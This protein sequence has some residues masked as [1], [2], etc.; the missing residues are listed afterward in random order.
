[1]K[2]AI[3]SDSHDNLANIYKFLDYINKEGICYVIH[4][5]DLCAPAV[6]REIIQKYDGEFHLVFG[7]VDGDHA[8]EEK[9]AEAAKGRVTIH[10]EEGKI[11]IDGVKIGFTHT[12]V[13]ARKMAES[14][15]FDFIFYG[16]TH[17]PWEELVGKTRLINP[18]TLAGMFNLATFAI[19]DTETRKLELKILEKIQI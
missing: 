1:M 2:I 10:G 9:F 13:R 11:E 12:P 17:K 19:L 18:G 4:C 5:G 6:L 8:G 3:V 7:N 14:E 15:P 16:H